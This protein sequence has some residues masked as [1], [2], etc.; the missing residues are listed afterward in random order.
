MLSSPYYLLE[1][2][3]IVTRIIYS[4]VSTHKMQ[5]GDMKLNIDP[6]QIKP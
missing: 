4:S 3:V 1:Q 5:P 2:S 6:N